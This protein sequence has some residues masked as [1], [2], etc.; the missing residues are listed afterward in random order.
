MP[1]VGW[2]S[3]LPASNPHAW[4]LSLSSTF[5][6]KPSLSTCSPPCRRLLRHKVPR[7]RL[8]F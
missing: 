7:A 5:S 3:L 4:Q 8:L 6:R 1:L 2:D